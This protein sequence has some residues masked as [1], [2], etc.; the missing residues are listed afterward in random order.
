MRIYIFLLILAGTAGFSS[1]AI[2]QGQLYTG[3][4][5]GSAV[6][7]VPSDLLV[8]G[9]VISSENIDDSDTAL[10]FIMGYE[11]SRAVALEIGYIDLG[12]AGVKG[13]SD[14]T[15]AFWTAGSASIQQESTALFIDVLGIYA[16]NR[17]FQLLGKVGF[18]DVDQD[19][20]VIGS[21]GSG[22]SSDSNSDLLVGVGAAYNFTPD[23]SLRLDWTRYKHVGKDLFTEGD[24]DVLGLVLILDFD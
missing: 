16:I 15:G 4:G 17:R 6:T 10:S 22:K 5:F 8:D 14:G 3:L 12:E 19:F 2:A 20:K 18:Y 21:T 24:I 23:F 9:S 13:V 7:D 11:F 1:L